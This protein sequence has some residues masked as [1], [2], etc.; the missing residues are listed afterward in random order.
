MATVTPDPTADRETEL[1]TELN[2]LRA[3]RTSILSGGQSASMDGVSKTK[4][5]LNEINRRI[6]EINRSL[7]R[8][9][10]GGR[11]ITVD[12]TNA[13]PSG[14]LPQSLTGV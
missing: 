5:S 7:Q 14:S 10:Y 3:A 1:L 6:K 8:L 12:V 13:T 11:M 9:R 2:E 4:A